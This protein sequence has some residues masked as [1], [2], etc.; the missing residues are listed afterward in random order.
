MDITAARKIEVTYM[1]L[2]CDEKVSIS[3]ANMVAPLFNLEKCVGKQSCPQCK[4]LLQITK[5]KFRP[6]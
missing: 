5:I 2:K 6:L 4:G 1:C 3:F